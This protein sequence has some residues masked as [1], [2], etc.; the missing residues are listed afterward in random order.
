MWGDRILN[1]PRCENSAFVK[2]MVLDGQESLII[3]AVAPVAV[4]A[5]VG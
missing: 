2:H 3:A 1:V 4:I 5:I